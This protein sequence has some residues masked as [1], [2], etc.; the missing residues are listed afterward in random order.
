MIIDLKQT[1][2][3]A[4]ELYSLYGYNILNY[5]L[6]FVQRTL[7]KFANEYR[8]KDVDSLRKKLLHDET[9]IHDFF[10]KLFINVSSMFR[11]PKVFE[12][13]REKIMPYISSHP[14]IKVWSAGCARGQEVY[15][16]AI[17]LKELGVYDRCVLYATD[18][19]INAVNSAREGRYKT[20]DSLEYFENYYLS[21]GK[22]KFSKYFDIKGD[23]LIVKDDL[24]KNICFATHNIIT[25]DVFNTFSLILCRNMFIYFDNDL[26]S[27][28]LITFRDSLEPSGFLVMGNSESMHF[29]GGYT[30]FKNYDEKNKIYKIKG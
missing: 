6:S 22:E 25:D 17:L 27:K 16:L 12:V 24:K 30:Y 20:S 9:L 23:E 10:D 4:Q 18:I 26:Q 15:S 5:D 14:T 11:D 21:G 1:D 29:N 3:I 2:E 7:I 19:D 8:C 13:I 28:G